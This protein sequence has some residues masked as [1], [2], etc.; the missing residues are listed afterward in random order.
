MS[1]IM[2]PK[3]A[4]QKETFAHR[5]DAVAEAKRISRI[6]KL[7]VFVIVQERM[8]YTIKRDVQVQSFDITSGAFLN[9]IEITK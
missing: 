6:W 9:G 7:K 2:V 3:I 5:K 8:L 4:E 1:A